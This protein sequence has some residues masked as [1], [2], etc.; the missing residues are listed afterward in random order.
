MTWPYQSSSVAS[1]NIWQ[2]FSKEMKVVVEELDALVGQGEAIIPSTWEL[3]L[4]V[5]LRVKGLDLKTLIIIC[6]EFVHL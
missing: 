2:D 6:F 1:S 3:I 5:S 4:E